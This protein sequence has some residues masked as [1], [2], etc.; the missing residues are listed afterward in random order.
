MVTKHVYVAP[1]DA[2]ARADA[3][4]P[5]MW[6]R[7]AFIRSLSPDGIAGLPPSVYEGAQAMITRLRSQTWHDL[8][9]SALFIGSPETVAQKIVELE[10]AGVGELACWMSFGGLPQ[11]RVRRSMEL[12]ASEVM[13]RF[14]G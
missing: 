1:T 6:Y 14:R 3:E 2:E 7:D 8:L 5:E 9:E 4:A 12:F 11:D 13:P 10:E